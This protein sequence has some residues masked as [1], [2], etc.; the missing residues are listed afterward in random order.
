MLSETE[1]L[2]IY[3]DCSSNVIA[4]NAAPT[5]EIRGSQNC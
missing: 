5:N 4:R 3:A 2:Q 1:N